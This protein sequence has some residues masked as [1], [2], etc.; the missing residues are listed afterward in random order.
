MTPA[1]KAAREAVVRAAMQRYE[2]DRLFSTGGRDWM[3]HGAN[4]DIALYDACA[5]LAAARKSRARHR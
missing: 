1:E 2:H 5:H 3:K 4:N